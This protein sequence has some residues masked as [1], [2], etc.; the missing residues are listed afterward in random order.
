M[1][2]LL[3][4]VAFSSTVTVFHP[5]NERPQVV[6]VLADRNEGHKRDVMIHSR[7]NAQD[8][9]KDNN[10]A[11]VLALLTWAEFA[12]IMKQMSTRP[13]SKIYNVCFKKKSLLYKLQKS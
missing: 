4:V 12:I 7:V 1:D 9:E 11:A 8:Q 5:F 10:W 13:V 3:W 6:Q 2:K